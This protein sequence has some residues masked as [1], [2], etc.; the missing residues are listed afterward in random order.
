[1]HTQTPNCTHTRH[2]TS[3]HIDEH[4]TRLEGRVSFFRAHLPCAH[5]SA[6]LRTR[7]SQLSSD[8]RVPPSFLLLSPSHQTMSMCPPTVVFFISCFL[9]SHQTMTVGLHCVHVDCTVP[10]ASTSLIRPYMAVG[11]HWSRVITPNQRA[12]AQG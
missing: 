10:F 12:S 6:P 8:H 7:T 9:R 11:L 3:A 1:M 5:P 2:S 4:M